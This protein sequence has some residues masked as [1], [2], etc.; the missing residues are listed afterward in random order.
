MPWIVNRLP[1]DEASLDLLFQVHDFRHF[2]TSY[3]DLGAIFLP[4]FLNVR[5]RA[6]RGNCFGVYIIVALGIVLFDML[7]ISGLLEARNCP[8]QPPK[9]IVYFW[10]TMSNGFEVG[11]EMLHCVCQPSDAHP[12]DIDETHHRQRRSAQ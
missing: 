1:F 8:V 12:L 11:L 10:I 7:E 5:E 4:T 2:H 6:H 9:P 3:R